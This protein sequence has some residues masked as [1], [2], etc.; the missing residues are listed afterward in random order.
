M[1]STCEP[2]IKQEVSA[3]LYKLALIYELM[4]SHTELSH[5]FTI[6]AFSLK[7]LKD[8]SKYQWFY[9]PYTPRVY[10]ENQ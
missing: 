7:L 8:S 10:R 5:S 2:V 9:F 3:L 4:N 1:L 6:H